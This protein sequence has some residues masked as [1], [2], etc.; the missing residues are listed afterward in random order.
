M[1]ASPWILN[2][3]AVFV[4]LGAAGLSAQ[5]ARPPGP[6]PRGATGAA[7]P[8]VRP[9]AAVVKIVHL[10]ELKERMLADGSEPAG[11]SPDQFCAFLQDEIA[12]KDNIVLN[13]S[14]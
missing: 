2:G 7:A 1:K 14:K 11:N 4:L 12:S 6:S 5:T 9:A 13:I 8:A 10:P 3:L